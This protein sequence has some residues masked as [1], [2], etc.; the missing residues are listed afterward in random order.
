V[1]DLANYC[2]HQ[3]GSCKAAEVSKAKRHDEQ[4]TAIMGCVAGG[5]RGVHRGWVG[6]C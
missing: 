4:W 1:V 3:G 5:W 6:R 2:Y